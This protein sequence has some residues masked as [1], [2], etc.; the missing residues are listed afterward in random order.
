MA[1]TRHGHHIVGTSISDSYPGNVV[2]CGGPGLC[3][4]CSLDAAGYPEYDGPL[5]AEKPSAGDSEETFQEKAERIVYE[6]VCDRL[7]DEV[8]SRV[9][10]SSIFVVWFSK[11][12]QNWKALVSTTLPDEMYYEVTHNGDKHETYLDVYSKFHN[13]VIPD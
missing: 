4:Q 2:R 1:S 5:H 11:T 12:L 3:S 7:E 9:Q 13:F 6:Y 10:R 8:G